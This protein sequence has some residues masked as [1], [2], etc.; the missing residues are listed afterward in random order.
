MQLTTPTLEDLWSQ[1]P[2]SHDVWSH[3]EPGYHVQV[4]W[5][6]VVELTCG[7]LWHLEQATSLRSLDN[8]RYAELRDVD[9]KPWATW[10]QSRTPAASAMAPLAI[11]NIQSMLLA[12]AA[13]R[14]AGA[15]DILEDMAKRGDCPSVKKLGTLNSA[16]DQEG[17]VL[18]SADPRLKEL[19]VL[20]AIRDSFMHGELALDEDNKR[21]KHRKS[22]Y[23]SESNAPQA[24]LDICARAAALLLQLFYREYRQDA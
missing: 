3:V 12:D 11:T 20:R 16:T 4:R 24:L 7:A 18:L 19:L 1:V 10:L 5:R 13:L 9:S 8:E 6:E 15:W 21:K 2:R 22:L 14:L 23:K 17:N